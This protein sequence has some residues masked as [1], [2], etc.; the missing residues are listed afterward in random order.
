MN[1]GGWVLLVNAIC[2]FYL[3]GLIWTVQRVHYPA[4]AEIAPERF[5]VF[6]A[7]H[8][9]DI[10]PVV[11]PVMLAELFSA[12]GLLVLRPAVMPMPVAIVGAGL[13]ALVWWSTIALQVPLHTRL[14]AGF[15]REAVRGLIRTN[16]IRTFAWSARAGLIA[17]VLTR[18]MSFGDA[19]A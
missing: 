1:V 18:A 6:E 4:F 11:A 15:D 5:I 12:L 3:L 17:W 14:A 16:W 8:Q 19:P 13:V 7:A 9:R 10:T 2:T